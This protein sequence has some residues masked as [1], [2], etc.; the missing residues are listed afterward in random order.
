MGTKNFSTEK[1]R[2]LFQLKKGED[3]FSAEKGANTFSVFFPKPA[4]VVNF[5]RFLVCTNS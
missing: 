2:R 3:F 5:D 4:K 1:G